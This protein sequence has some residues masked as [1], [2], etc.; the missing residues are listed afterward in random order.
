MIDVIGL[1]CIPLAAKFRI[2]QK[3]RDVRFTDLTSLLAEFKKEDLK[4]A[5]KS[6]IEFRTATTFP[7]QM[8]C[9]DAC[10]TAK[11]ARLLAQ[12]DGVQGAYQNGWFIGLWDFVHSRGRLPT[13]REAQELIAT[14]SQDW[15]NLID[16]AKGSSFAITARG[17][18]DFYRQRAELVGITTTHM[19][20]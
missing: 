15:H 16:A 18:L 10:A 1:F 9:F 11:V 13:G 8:E 19:A 20:A 4:V 14:A 3:I 7:S 2:G 12:L 5:A 17:I 6:L